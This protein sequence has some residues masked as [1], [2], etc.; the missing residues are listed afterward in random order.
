MA[1]KI[2]I[3][4]MIEVDPERRN[5]DLINLVLSIVFV[6]AL[7]FNSIKFLIIMLF[8]LIQTNAVSIYLRAK[9]ES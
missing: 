8:I 6:V 1:R 2:K 7:F 5:W 4:D 3:M 9:N